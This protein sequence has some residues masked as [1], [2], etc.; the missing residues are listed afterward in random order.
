MVSLKIIKF[1]GVCGIFV[2]IVFLSILFLSIQQVSWFS[3]TENAISDLGSQDGA[4]FIF[5]NG[6]IIT[7][8]LFLFFSIGLSRE[9][10]DRYASPLFFSLSAIFLIGLGL[11]PVP[12]IVHIYLSGLFFGAL[13]YAFFAF[14]FSFYNDTLHF[15][16]KMA[17]FAILNLILILIS[18]IFLLYF[19]GVAIPEMIIIFP[20]FIWCVLFGLKMVVIQS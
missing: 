11:V 7:G 12:D 1:S 16:R 20:G 14:G 2:L 13:G 8:I 5:N 19:E 15:F 4:P 17:I 10:K 3:W 9:L 18:P 6:L